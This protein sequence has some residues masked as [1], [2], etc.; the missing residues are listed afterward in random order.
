MSARFDVVQEILRP[1]YLRIYLWMGFQRCSPSPL[2]PCASSL[3]NDSEPES[4]YQ[5]PCEADELSLAELVFI[6][7]HT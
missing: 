1:Y 3:T 6:P 5:Q 4:Q 7:L 2:P